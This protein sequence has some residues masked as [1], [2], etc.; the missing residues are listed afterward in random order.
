[1]SAYIVPAETIHVLAAWASVSESPFGLKMVNEAKAREA[2][3]VLF[4]ENAR[5]VGH[6]YS[7]NPRPSSPEFLNADFASIIQNYRA[8]LCLAAARGYEYQ[9]C[10]C[11]D[12]ET[13][14]AANLVSRAIKNASER[15]CELAGIGCWTVGSDEMRLARK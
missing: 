13:T 3:R 10:E 5:S 9:A 11:S 2:C 12:Y 6:R 1:M 14:A 8:E 4:A 7:V 15:L